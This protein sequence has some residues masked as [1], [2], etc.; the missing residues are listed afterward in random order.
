LKVLQLTDFHVD[1][2]YTP[3]NDASCGEE[4]C[5]RAEHGLP[6]NSDDAAG[7]WGDYRDCD[8]PVH[9]FENL[10]QQAATHTV[11]FSSI[12]GVILIL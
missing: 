5:C 10:V 6:S 4:I 3:G 12:I 7:Y 11:K 1:T 8:M 2:E 9:T